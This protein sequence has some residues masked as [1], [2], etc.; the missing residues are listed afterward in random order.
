MA[1]NDK[2]DRKRHIVNRVRAQ[3][4]MKGI[5]FEIEVEDV[6]W[7]A[8]CPILDIPLEYFA[9]G[10]RRQN[11]VSLDR[12][13]STVGYIKGN[14][15]TISVRANSIKSNLTLSQA[16]KL[17]DYIDSHLTRKDDRTT[18]TTT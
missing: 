2:H 9:T 17:V 16:I 3:A 10:G 14:V 6:E 11:S 7:N 18:G 13:D 8:V 15:S 5:L 12:I 4:K 1:G